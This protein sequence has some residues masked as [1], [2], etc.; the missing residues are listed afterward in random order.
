MTTEEVPPGTVEFL[1]AER[2][3]LLGLVGRLTKE[4][5]EYDTPAWRANEELNQ[6][7]LRMTDVIAEEVRC[8]SHL[9]N[10]LTGRVEG[11]AARKFFA[12]ID[13]A[14]Q[15]LGEELT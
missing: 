3:R 7:V 15:R 5:E 9:R 13:R 4:A 1:L 10:E 14:I 12:V 2:H 6:Q 11:E 8:L